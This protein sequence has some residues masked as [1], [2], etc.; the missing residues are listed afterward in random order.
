MKCVG[1]RLLGQYAGTDE[2]SHELSDIRRTPENGQAFDDIQTLFRSLRVSSRNL[3]DHFLRYEYFKLVTLVGPPGLSN[4][5]MGGDDLVSARFRSQVADDGC[6][7]IQA[8]H[9]TRKEARNVISA[10]ASQA[11][12]TLPTATLRRNRLVQI[13]VHPGAQFFAR[14]VIDFKFDLLARH[15][16]RL[17]G[18]AQQFQMHFEC[19]SK[20]LS[21][22]LDRSGR[23]DTSGNV[24]S[25]DAIAPIG[26]TNH[27]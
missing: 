26:S 3:V 11:R 10:W 2:P 22:T 18:V 7:E 15:G 8:R 24:R 1:G 9:G 27:H 21:R 14:V 4:Q 23:S 17:T 5:L 6:F 12:P 20:H 19:F 16:N 13:N 25:I